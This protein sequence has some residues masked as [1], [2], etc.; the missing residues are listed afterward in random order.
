MKV[1]AAAVEFVDRRYSL[2]ILIDV[3][4]VIQAV[5]GQ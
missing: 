3:P 2:P 4:S 1:S 5:V